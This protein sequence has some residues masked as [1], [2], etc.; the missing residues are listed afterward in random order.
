MPREA[1][2]LTQRHVERLTE[3]G[4]HAVGGV[5]GLYL[6]VGPA[7][8]RS[9]VLRTMVEGRRRHLGLGGFPGVSLAQARER[10]A[11]LREEHDRQRH[12]DAAIERLAPLTSSA[13]ATSP[14]RTGF[15]MLVDTLERVG[16][17]A[18]KPA[19]RGRAVTDAP[20]AAEGDPLAAALRLAEQGR[21]DEA[22]AA[23]LALRPALMVEADEA[24]RGLCEFVLLRSHQNCGRSADAVAAGSRAVRWQQS[25]AD[26]APLLYT[27]DVLAWALACVG[28]AGGALDVLERARQ[29]LPRLADR[30]RDRALFHSYCSI[31]LHTL[32]LPQEAVPESEHAI[33]L[34]E[35]CGELRRRDIARE[36]LLGQRLDLEVRHCDGRPTP[37][38]DALLAEFHG[39]IER[40]LRD[41]LHWSVAKSAE[42]VADAWLASGRTEQA[43]AILLVG[44]RSA[45]LAKAGPDQGVLEWRLAR[46]ERLA[47]QYR[48]ASSRLQLALQLVTQGNVLRELA[49]VHLEAMHLHEAR[50]HWRA[51]LE[52]HKQYA[53]V[54]ERLLMAQMA[55]RR[56]GLAVPLE[57]DRAAA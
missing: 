37:A 44:I 29:L 10:A 6:Y 11:R 47:G 55:S 5:A 15:H 51:A 45:E 57:P 41:G 13:P 26:V 32:G 3:V 56:H 30:P 9:W 36:N 38:L 43:R 7:R 48:L 23:C 16:Q 27:L 18:D 53:Q 42:F 20:A 35:A 21:F 28:D 52:S 17:R 50:Q 40:N 34:F 54:R 31:T 1:V 39:H 4:H 12:A 8:S 24:R 33:A 46:I 22:I 2:P 14:A 25:Q 49:N 19:R